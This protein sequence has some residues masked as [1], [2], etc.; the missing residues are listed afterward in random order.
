M[1]AMEVGR[2]TFRQRPLSLCRGR[3]DRAPNNVG[4]F[5]CATQPMWH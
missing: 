4:E 3:D 2:M 5:V 1:K